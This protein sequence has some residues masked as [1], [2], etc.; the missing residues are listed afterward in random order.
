MVDFYRKIR[1]SI[2]F[3]AQQICRLQNTK[4]SVR[5]VLRNLCSINT[6]EPIN[7][8]DEFHH[9]LFWASASLAKC[10][11]EIQRILQSL[12]SF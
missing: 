1:F 7:L 10:S 6:N 11:K 5:F 12:M 2:R 3:N 4:R 9:K 8:C